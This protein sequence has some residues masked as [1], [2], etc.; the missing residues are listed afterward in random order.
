[1]HSVFCTS[2]L[3][4]FTLIKLIAFRSQKKKKK[5]S[6]KNLEFYFNFCSK[7]SKSKLVNFFMKVKILLYFKEFQEFQNKIQN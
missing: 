4:L 6:F 2:R 7:L 1:M 3:G 5:L